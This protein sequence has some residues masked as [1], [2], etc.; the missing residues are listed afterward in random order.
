MINIG[1]GIGWAKA[2]YSVANNVIANFKARVLSYPNSIFEAGPCLDATLEELNAIGLL[3]NAS[4]VITPN[5]YNEGILYDVIPNTTLGDMDVVRA[6]TATRVNSAGLIEVVPRNLLTYSEQF[7]NVAWTIRNST[8]SANITIAPNGTLTA[9]KLIEDVT[10]AEHW[11]F[12]ST[13][14]TI[15]SATI[16]CYMKKGERNWG[17]IRTRTSVNDFYAWF[18]LD[19]GSIGT[20]QSGITASIIDAG[21]GWYKCIVTNPNPTTAANPSVIGISNSDN[22]FSYTGN[23]TSGIFIWGAQF[24]QGSTATEYFPTTTRLNIPRIDYTNGSCPSLLVEPQ[25][26]NLLQRSEEFDNGIWGKVNVVITADSII[27]PNGTQNADLIS[28]NSTTNFLAFSLTNAITS[29][30]TISVFAK[31]GTGSVLRIREIN[32]FGTSSTFDLNAGTVLSGT[33]KIEN[34]GNG[35]YRC[36][37]TQAYTNLQ[38]PINWSFDSNSN[39]NNLYLWGAQLEAGAYPTSYIPTVATT[40]TRNADLISNNNLISKGLIVNDYV[41]FLDITNPILGNQYIL[42]STDISSI[43]TGILRVDGTTA[44]ITD[45][46]GGISI[47][48]LNILTIGKGKMCVKRT[49]STLSFF[50]NG[51]K[52][53]STTTTTAGTINNLKTGVTNSTTSSYINSIELFPIAL[54]DTECISL[55]TL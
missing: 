49:G 15:S 42:D 39:I 5:A 3:D 13:T 10:T 22:V 32:I 20:V 2:L 37:I 46:T 33:G 19:N 25:R 47:S 31:K 1:I 45:I 50:A 18:N 34:Y 43:R 17:F 27:S 41:L 6:T 30:Y 38:T 52:A 23:G 55:T 4:L 16:S 14:N 12:Q 21:N 7:Q 24:E 48:I 36:S 40:V 29:S 53:A 54:T 35:W 44:S 8:I 26:T 11:V 51:V 9:D 28:Y